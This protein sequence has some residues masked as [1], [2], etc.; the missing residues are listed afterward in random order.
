MVLA[1]GFHQAKLETGADLMAL[2]TLD[3]KLRVVLSCLVD[4][5]AKINIP[6][7]AS[8]TAAVVLYLWRAGYLAAWLGQ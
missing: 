6:F 8:F 5:R 2:E 7:G 4:A 1:G 3:Q